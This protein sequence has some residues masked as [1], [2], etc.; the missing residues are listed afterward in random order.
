MSSK[1]KINKN[2][3]FSILKNVFG[4][5]FPLITFPYVSR[6]LQPEN[7]GKIDFSSSIISYLALFASLGIPT[8]AIRECS[9]VRNDRDKLSKVSSEIYS[10]NLMATFFSYVVFLIFLLVNS[11]LMN[12]KALI[13]L[14]SITVILSTLGTEWLNTAMENFRY[15]TLCTIITQILSVVFMLTFVRTKEDY[16]KYAIIIVLSSGGANVF[17]IF[18]RKKYCDVRFTLNMNLKKHIIPIV[19]MFGFLISSIIC[20]NSDITIIGFIQGDREVGLYSTAVKIYNLA[21]TVVA[22]ITWVVLPKLSIGFSRKDY[23]EVNGLLKYALNFIVILGM[24][25]V[26]GIEAL[27]PHLISFIAGDSYV[28]ASLSLRFLG[29]ALL[30]SFFGGWLGNLNMLPAGRELVFLISTA[31]SAIV[32]IALNLIF[33]PKW[34]FNAAAVTT[35]IS[36]MIGIFVLF[37]FLDKNVH[38]T[39]VLKILRA[40]LIGTIGVVMICTIVQKFVLKSWLI[41]VISIMISIIVYIAILLIMKDAFFIDYIEPICRVLRRKFIKIKG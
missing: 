36:Q 7:I 18:Y 41:S 32:N 22:S 1:S 21:N 10:I 11:S 35:A 28:S 16:I 37:P 27:A 30:L 4:I 6:V 23:E 19:V 15:I 29:I 40:P 31:L 12:Y 26:A 33:I 13:I 9:K 25:T 2:V 17:N 38:I 24:P 8:Y 34:G 39:G 20:T 14:Q 5:I 3:I